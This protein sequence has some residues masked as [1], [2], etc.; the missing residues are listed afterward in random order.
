[1]VLLEDR[2]DELIDYIKVSLSHYS[3]NVPN[4]V[5]YI[6]YRRAIGS[7]HSRVYYPIPDHVTCNTPIISLLYLAIEKDVWITFDEKD[8]WIIDIL[9]PRVPKELELLEHMIRRFIGV[10][11][12]PIIVEKI[13]DAGCHHLIRDMI[14]YD[15]NVRMSET[16]KRATFHA[17]VKAIVEDNKTRID[18][19]ISILPKIS[20]RA[21]LYDFICILRD[22]SSTSDDDIIR[23]LWYLFMFVFSPVDVV[24][25]F[26]LLFSHH[27]PKK[28]IMALAS[29]MEVILSSGDKR[30]YHGCYPTVCIG[31][32]PILVRHVPIRMYINDDDRNAMIKLITEMVYYYP[33]L[34][35][36]M[37]VSDHTLGS[38]QNHIWNPQSSPFI[39]DVIEADHEVV[40]LMTGKRRNGKVMIG[41]LLTS[42]YGAFGKSAMQRIDFTDVQILVKRSC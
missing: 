5:G 33:T 2:T 15:F 7:G 32:H 12:S 21:E 6:D 16:V 24:H 35:S 14:D 31:H 8:A 19:I 41:E 42:R 11:Y 23:V 26:G 39:S 37:V 25:V 20:H 34:V 18:D 22:F 13:V 10:K 38:S 4:L 27:R 1:M 3:D 17:L 40:E 30:N 36:S 29:Y 28:I 9:D